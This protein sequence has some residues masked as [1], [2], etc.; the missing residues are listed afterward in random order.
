MDRKMTKTCV[1]P[2]KKKIN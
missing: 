2:I 1:Y